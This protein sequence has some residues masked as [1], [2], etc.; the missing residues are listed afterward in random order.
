MR[1]FELPGGSF[2]RRETFKTLPKLLKLCGNPMGSRYVHVDEPSTWGTGAFAAKDF[3][4]V[5]GEALLAALQASLTHD[6]YV[7][8][9]G[10]KMPWAVWRY[11]AFFLPPCA[12]LSITFPV[13]MRAVS[14]Q[15][16][17][18]PCMPTQ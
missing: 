8:E 18:L 14:D 1:W 10:M 11:G 5:S 9:F 7:I 12:P 3:S 13:S 4:G 2:Q 6:L 15:R 16:C 17:V